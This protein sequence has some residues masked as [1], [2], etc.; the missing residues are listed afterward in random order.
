MQL[1]DTTIRRLLSH[2]LTDVMIR[3]GLIALVVVLCVRIFAPFL[4]VMLWALILAVAL[5]PLHQRLAAWLRGRQGPAA[6]LLILIGLLL[7]GAPTV[8]LGGSFAGYVQDT[9]T[10]IETGSISISEPSPAIADWPLVGKEIHAAWSAA[11][12]D[13][14]QFVREHREQIEGLS[15]RA[16]SAAA[17]TLGSVLLFLVSLIIAGIMMAYG[18]SG[19]MAMRRILSRLTGPARGPRL[20]R[21]STATIRSVATGV[22]GVA[23]IQA[24]LLGSGFVLAGIPAAGVLA[25]IVLLLGIAQLPAALVFLPAIAWLWMSGDGST[26]SN[27]VFTAYLV[28]AGL[29]DNVLKPLLLGRGVDAPM[30]VVLLGA[31][32]GMVSAG[33]IG[34]FI[35]AVVLAIGYQVFMEWVNEAETTTGGGSQEAEPVAPTPPPG[36]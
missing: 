18:E 32:G 2:D 4:G 30:P 22:I 24:L 8:M 33:I 26:T 29:A 13:L 1:D 16:I 20:H 6:T 17:S 5:Y 19:S 3:I 34:L 35:G 31:I 10:A 11:A 28:L 12:A 15:K 25:V 36:G 9:F 14:P 23:F 21:L 7:I 27:I